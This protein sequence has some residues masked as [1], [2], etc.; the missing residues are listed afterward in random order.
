MALANELRAQLRSALLTAVAEAGVDWLAHKFLVRPQ[1]FPGSEQI[2]EE[3]AEQLQ[4][5]DSVPP[6]HVGWHGDG[7]APEWVGRLSNTE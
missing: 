5:R 7:P 2:S 4:A 1:P 3:S 6:V